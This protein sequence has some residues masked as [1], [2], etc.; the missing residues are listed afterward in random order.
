MR[1]SLERRAAT[2]LAEAGK[3]LELV[4]GEEYI[5][6]SSKP[7][8]GGRVRIDELNLSNGTFRLTIT[9]SG[10]T[11]S[12]R[13]SRWGI[14]GELQEGLDRIAPSDEYTKDLSP[15][16]RKQRLEAIVRLRRALESRT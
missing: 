15:A 16:L 10:G 9:R 13:E 5:P 1:S 12:L 4:V 7:H 11:G 2:P 8:W 14:I 6:F 3:R